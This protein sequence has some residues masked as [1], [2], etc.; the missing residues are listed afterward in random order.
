M[1]VV[2]TSEARAA[3]TGRALAA[4]APDT[5][6]LVLPPWDCLPYDRASPSRASMGKRVAVLHRLTNPADGPR[7]LVTSAEAALQM[8]PPRKVVLDC[9]FTFAV[10]DVFDAERFRGF[11]DRAGYIFDDRVDEPGEV[12]MMGHAV[13]IFPADAGVP[14][15]LML[16]EDGRI[17][18]ISSY[19]PITQRTEVPLDALVIGSATELIQDES[20]EGT[21]ASGG[22][23]EHRLA[24]HYQQLET[25]FTLMP[26]ASLFVSEAAEE[27]LHDVFELIAEA[28][29]ARRLFA[30]EIHGLPRRAL[31]LDAPEWEECT[32]RRDRIAIDLETLEPVPK[33]A[34]STRPARALGQFVRQQWEAGRRVLVTGQEGE[35]KRLAS[36]LRRAKVDAVP[37]QTLD[38]L[39][40]LASEEIGNA[41]F[42]LDAGF[43]ETKAAVAIVAAPDLLGARVYDGPAL[44]LDGVLDEPELRVG[45]VVI[46]ED[47]GVGVLRALEQVEVDGETRDVVRL[48]YKDG[49]SLLAPVEEFGKIWRYGSEE[50]AVALDRLKGDGWR[51]RRGEISAEIDAVAGELVRLA[52]ERSREKGQP[53]T[54]LARPIAGL[55]RAFHIRKR[56]TRA[57]PSRPC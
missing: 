18:A 31:H 43:I 52:D 9:R 7:V 37:V 47:H 26:D 57:R 42:D 46:H 19:D 17:E 11:A 54:R 35:L 8:L 30:G 39:E 12:A 45:D 29:E 55:R 4:F 24:D 14:S 34:L 22:G 20:G 33:F 23:I 10:G 44:S 6:V 21:P 41:P 27:R 38:D 56:P 36:L 16:S 50:E 13:D 3:E 15:R 40:H 25:I 48:E 51:R 32:S 53:S 5:E 28:R 49:A 1:I 2:T